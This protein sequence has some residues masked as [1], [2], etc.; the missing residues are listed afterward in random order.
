[1]RTGTAGF[2]PGRLRLARETRGMTVTALAEAI[3][4]T[5]QVIHKYEDGTHSPGYEILSRLATALSVPVHYFVKPLRPSQRSAFFA[6]SMSAVTKAARTRAENILVR[7]EELA[8]D[9]EAN[10]TLHDVD[11]PGLDIGADPLALSMNDIEDA[12]SRL[13]RAWK[14]GDG[15]ISNVT[16]LLEN[17][18]IVVA[19]AH[20]DARTLDGISAWVNGRPY[21]LVNDEVP[22]GRQRF[23]LLHELAHVCLHRDVPEKALNSQATFKLIENQAHRFAAAFAFPA[24]SFAREAIPLS[25]DRFL[26]LKARWKMSIKMMIHRSGDL[27]LASPDY[28]TTLYRRYS[29]RKW[30]RLEPLDDTLPPEIPLMLGK[31]ATLIIESGRATDAD[32]LH[33]IGLLEHEAC[34]LASMRRPSLAPMNAEILAFPRQ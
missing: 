16:W 24:A 33:H 23:D 4:A 26:E 30:A 21:V 15:P 8:H 13:R 22:L 18:G 14:L 2:V 6:R 29:W 11:L 32:L 31:A 12:A 5:R 28:L 20:L 7:V 9:L 3:Q 19:R 27:M 17:H 1:M 34:S 25:L 10:A